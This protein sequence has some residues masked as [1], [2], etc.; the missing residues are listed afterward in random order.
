MSKEKPAGKPSETADDSGA[1]SLRSLLG[2][3]VLFGLGGVLDRALG[4]AF[5]PIT[6]ALLGV[7]GFGV[8][9]LYNAS[10]GI[11]TIMAALEVPNSFFR[12]YTDKTE[13]APAREWVATAFWIL[14]ALALVWVPLLLLFAAPVNELIFGIPGKFFVVCI[15]IRAYATAVK[16]LAD[17]RMQADGQVGRFL[18]IN[19]VSALLIRGLALAFLLAGYGAEG[20]AAGDAA[21]AVLGTLIA[22]GYG[23]R[24]LG[25]GASRHCARELFRYGSGL[26]PGTMA[27]WALTTTDKYLLRWLAPDA[28]RSVGLYS[29]GERISLV[30]NF[31]VQATSTGWRRFAFRNMHLEDGAQRIGRGVT[32]IMVTLG[33]LAL[34]LSLIGESVVRFVI[35]PEFI[36]GAVVIPILTL[37]AL[38][39]GAQELVRIGLLKAKRSFFLSMLMVGSAATNVG[40]NILWIPRFGLVGAAWASLA[41]AS[42]RLALSFYF[43]Q[44]D[45]RLDLEW[46][47]LAHVAAVYLAAMAAGSFI[48]WPSALA[49]AV[50]CVVIALLTPLAVVATGVL[51]PEE[52]ARLRGLAD[53]AQAMLRARRSGK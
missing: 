35:G 16:S 50:G 14:N 37:A 28:L 36:E 40:L 39:V 24:G 11:L 10:A 34:S 48:P 13:A 15:C 31:G 22:C 20:V 26:T 53:R 47:R 18:G 46:G 45:Y 49:Q 4:L 33:Y 5:L 44:R 2:D 32:V 29:V 41:A 17:A 23:L 3:S 52:L 7:T 6:A 8:I 25:A 21:G 51:R 30:M 42:M 43:S 9:S 1:V 19:A 12:F 38:F 27:G